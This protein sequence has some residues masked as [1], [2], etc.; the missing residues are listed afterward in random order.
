M[1]NADYQERCRN[2]RERI[3]Q[4]LLQ[5]AKDLGNAMH[6]TTPIRGSVP[7]SRSSASRRR[8]PS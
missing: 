4:A 5:Q 8:R 1:I 7:S 2:E 6:S 3:D